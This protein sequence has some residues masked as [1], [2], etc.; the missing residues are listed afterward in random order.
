MQNVHDIFDK[1][2]LYCNNG[3]TITLREFQSFLRVEQ[4]DRL[5]DDEAVAS[6]F[7][8]D[9]LRDPQRDT[10]EPYFT[11]HEVSIC[12]LLLYFFKDLRLI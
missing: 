8:R 2:S 12:I 10:Y 5:G 4:H 11:L 1:Y 6:Q 9:Y 7:I 3:S